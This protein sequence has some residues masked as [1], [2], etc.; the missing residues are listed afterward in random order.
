MS[1]GSAVTWNVIDF[2]TAGQPPIIRPVIPPVWRSIPG[3]ETD[4]RANTGNN[5]M[6]NRRDSLTEIANNAH[7]SVSHSPVVE[8]ATFEAVTDEH[9][10][11]VDLLEGV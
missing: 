2:E 8:G 1:R 11:E 3:S 9:V 7:A 5:V 10:V 4:D 6:V